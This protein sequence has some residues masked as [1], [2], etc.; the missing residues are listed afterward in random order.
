MQNAAKYGYEFRAEPK[1]LRG[2]QFDLE[3]IFKEYVFKLY[4]LRKGRWLWLRP[5]G[6]RRPSKPLKR[7]GAA[8]PATA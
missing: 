8:E 7:R 2:Y 1:V 3:D 6:L 4:N 5:R